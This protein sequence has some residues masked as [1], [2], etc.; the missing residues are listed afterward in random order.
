MQHLQSIVKVISER[1]IF[2]QI[3]RE[4][5][6]VVQCYNACAFLFQNGRD[7]GKG[8]GG[9]AANGGECAGNAESKIP[10]KR[11]EYAEL[12]SDLNYARL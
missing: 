11:L 3:T 4:S 6:P 12:H 9:G 7:G 5:R 8:K 2:R 10:D 1:N